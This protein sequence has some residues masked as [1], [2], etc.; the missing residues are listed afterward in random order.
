MEDLTKEDVK[1]DLTRIIN[2]GAE[3]VEAF[4][5]ELQKKDAAEV[6]SWS[7][8]STLVASIKARVAS[9]L[10]NSLG[11]WELS[12]LKVYATREAARAVQSIAGSRSTNV[13]DVAEKAA[14]GDFWSELAEALGAYR[15]VDK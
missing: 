14:R 7:A 8:E 5:K 15:D 3:V 1:Q 10:A 12:K 4:K 9:S 13:L 2:R 11:K 6:I